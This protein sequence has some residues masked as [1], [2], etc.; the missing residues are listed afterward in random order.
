M[1]HH[2]RETAVVSASPNVV[3]ANV[4]NEAILLDPVSS[5]YYS[6]SNVGRH[7]WGLIQTPTTL[8]ALRDAVVA[9]YDVD[10]AI[11]LDDLR[12]LVTHLVAAG[13]AVIHDAPPA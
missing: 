13:L 4:A 1:N 5:E 2:L 7:V 11:A 10:P 9:E 6:L 8:A 3:T 12:E